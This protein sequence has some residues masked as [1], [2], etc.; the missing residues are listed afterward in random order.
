ITTSKKVGKSVKRNRIRRLIRENYRL[1]EDFIRPG[2][3]LVF[4]SRVTEELPGFTE[5]RKEMK[6]LFKKLNVFDQEKWNCLK[7]V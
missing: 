3:D 4:V 5:I 6:F 7:G 1:F 2:Y